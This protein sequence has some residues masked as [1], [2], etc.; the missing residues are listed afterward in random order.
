M[1][2]GLAT[3]GDKKGD[4]TDR[5]GGKAHLLHPS[6]AGSLLH[7]VAHVYH[8][9]ADPIEVGDVCVKGDD[10]VVRDAEGDLGV[11]IAGLVGVRVDENLP[12]AVNRLIRP[13]ICRRA[14]SGVFLTNSDKTCNTQMLGVEVF[15]A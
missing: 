4:Y 6:F 9:V 10:A 5:Q 7:E 15:L 2:I 13:A 3:C 1:T 14:E 8:H 11:R 12:V